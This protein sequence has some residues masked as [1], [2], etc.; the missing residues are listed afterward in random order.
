MIANLARAHR[1]GE[2]QMSMKPAAE[3][4][5]YIIHLRPE[6]GVTDPIRMLRAFL[7]IAWRQFGLRALSA[8]ET[9]HQMRHQRRAHRVSKSKQAPHKESLMDMRQFKKPKFLKVPDIRSSDPARSAS[10][11][12]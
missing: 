3:R 11:V 5:I 4:P 1:G 7:K 9:K 10:S 2:A 12:P 6:P 8:H